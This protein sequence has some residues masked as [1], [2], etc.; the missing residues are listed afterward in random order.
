LTTMPGIR[1]L[2]A[3]LAAVL[4]LAMLS[5][6]GDDAGKKQD[7][8]SKAALACRA[9]WQQ[10]GEDIKPQVD[11]TQPSALPR[12]WNT[13]AA[14]V[15]YYRT[16]ATKADCGDRLDEQQQ[17]IASL[18]TFSARL[19]GFDMEAQL[20]LVKQDAQAYAAGPWPAAPTPSPTP[21]KQKKKRHK[22]QPKPVRPPK[23]ALVSQALATLTTQAPIATQQQGPGWEQASVVDLDDTEATAK[24]VKDLQFLSTQSSGW[25]SSQAALLLIRTA[26]A[27]KTG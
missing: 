8:P 27:A 7:Q 1:L 4:G 23:P 6:C 24:A 11:L 13:V 10:L 26:L 5:G 2:S 15:D 9:K 17:A 22:L 21:T 16:T 25:Q 20:A 3:A 18:K 19:T 14:T 12:R